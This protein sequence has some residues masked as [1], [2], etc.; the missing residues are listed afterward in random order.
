MENI[1]KVL[2]IAAG[3]LIV[4][5]LVTI[6]IKVFT[7]TQGIEEQTKGVGQSIGSATDKA[8][9]QLAASISSKKWRVNAD[10]KTYTSSDGKT[11]Q[12][13]R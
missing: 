10:G 1:S 11:V 4:V 13:R 7:S 6:G 12:F 8:T 2:L 9:Q 3:I 5:L